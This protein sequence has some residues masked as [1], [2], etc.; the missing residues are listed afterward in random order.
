[1]EIV[2]KAVTKAARQGHRSILLGN[3]SAHKPVC[4]QPFSGLRCRSAQS[5]SSSLERGRDNLMTNFGQPGDTTIEN[6]R[7]RLARHVSFAPVRKALPWARTAYLG[8]LHFTERHNVPVS[9]SSTSSSDKC[10]EIYP[11]GGS[12]A[13]SAPSQSV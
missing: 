1:M 9:F 3:G 6:Q 7:L 5:A 8:V 13:S 4:R 2:P 10:M 11:Q 12:K